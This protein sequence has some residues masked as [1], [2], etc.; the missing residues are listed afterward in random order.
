MLGWLAVPRTLQIL[1]K[2][3]N[4]EFGVTPQSFVLGKFWVD[5]AVVFGNFSAYTSFKHLKDCEQKLEKN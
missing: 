5:G 1:G 2:S 4:K 3:T